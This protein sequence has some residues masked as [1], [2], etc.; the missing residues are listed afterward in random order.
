MPLSIN[1]VTPPAV[2]PVSLATAKTHLRIDYDNSAE[3]ALITAFIVAARQ[4]AEKITHRA[5]FNQT[6]TLNLDCFPIY[7]WWSGTI[8][9]S[10][11]RTNWLARYGILRGQQILLPKPHLASVTSIKY[12]DVT[13]TQQTLSD[14]GYYVDNTSEPARLVPMPGLCWPATQTYMPGSVQ[15]TYVTGSYGDGTTVNT[16]PQTVCMAILLLVAHFY[17]NREATSGANLK[18]IPLGVEALLDTVKFNFWNY[19]NN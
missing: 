17:T 8:Q 2:E 13:G 4:Y 19:E 15:I 9:A 6:W 7:P 11:P 14:T 12:V 3:D 10:N 1:L 18:N 5:F 16:C